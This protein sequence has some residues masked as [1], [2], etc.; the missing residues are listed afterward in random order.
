M[1]AEVEAAGSVLDL[2]GRYGVTLVGLIIVS[3]GLWR[4]IKR[5]LDQYDA[6]K[7]SYLSRMQEL[8]TNFD[9]KETQFI[10]TLHEIQKTLI[11][12]NKLQTELAETNRL[13][14]DKIQQD[15]KEIGGNVALVLERLDRK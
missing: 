11:E 3:L 14:V 13:L 2:I 7:K 5:M 1:G 4:L 9:T 6:E 15:I 10:D 12:T 8:T